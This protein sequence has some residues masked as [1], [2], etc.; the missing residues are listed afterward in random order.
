MGVVRER[1]EDV[2]WILVGVWIGYTF[3]ER[4]LAVWSQNLKNTPIC[5]PK[6]FLLIDMSMDVQRFN[7]KILSSIDYNIAEL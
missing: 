1:V 2:N 3:P 5:P 7:H 6:Q 4:N